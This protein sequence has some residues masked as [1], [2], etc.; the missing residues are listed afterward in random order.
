MAAQRKLN[1][2][3]GMSFSEIDKRSADIDQ[4]LI[5]F[6]HDREQQT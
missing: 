4:L 3:A 5:F 6:K 2:N 1:G